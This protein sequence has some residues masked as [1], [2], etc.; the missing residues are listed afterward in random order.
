MT[1]PRV[2]HMCLPLMNVVRMKS[3]P[4]LQLLQL[5]E[6]LLRTSSDNWFIVNDGTIHPAIVMGL[7]GKLSELAEL[8]HVLHDS[9]PVIKRFTGG[10]T[11]IVDDG[12]I[13]AAIIC[14]KDDVPGVQPYPRSIMSWTSKLYG[15]VFRGFGNFHLREND[16]AFDTRKFGGNAQSITKNQWIHHTSFLWNYDVKNM[17]YLKLPMR[18]SKYR[19]A[20]DHVE[21]LCKMKEY[22]P[23]RSIFI[24][25]TITSLENHFSVRHVQAETI[26]DPSESSFSPSTRLLL[27]KELQEAYSSQTS[28]QQ[29]LR[30]TLFSE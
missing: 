1:M 23:S 24:E 9:I 22:L 3:M 30:S 7:S 26:F 17:D 5:E 6:R 13:F 25:R 12:T 19:L 20:R 29:S 27:E 8:K 15:E 18:A 2:K 16:Y 11:V 10:G 4:I 28:R 21:F 14:N